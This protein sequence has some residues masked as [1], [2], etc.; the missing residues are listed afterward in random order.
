MIWLYSILL[1][2]HLLGFVSMR[3]LPLT[4]GSVEEISLKANE[5]IKLIYK[6]DIDSKDAFW[7]FEAHSQDNADQLVLSQDEKQMHHPMVQVGNHQGLVFRLQGDDSNATK[8]FAYLTNKRRDRDVDLVVLLQ[9]YS[10]EYPVPGFISQSSANQN[11][12]HLSYYANTIE[13]EFHQASTLESTNEES[14]VLSYGVYQHYLAE[15]NLDQQSFLSHLSTSMLNLQD[16]MDNGHGVDDDFVVFINDTKGK[17][18][19]AAYPGTGVIFSV[20]ATRS[21]SDANGTKH[22]S[23]LY[24]STSTYAC[25]LERTD[26][27]PLNC[28]IM[29]Y[30]ITKVIC[31]A[32][33]FVG[34]LRPPNAFYRLILI[35]CFL[36]AYVAFFGHR[37]F[38]VITILSCFNDS[39]NLP[40]LIFYR[41]RSSYLALMARECALLSS[42]R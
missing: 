22:Y 17:V 35:S 32:S 26:D 7:T 41:L 11:T 29:W 23:S 37:S 5:T 38:T 2:N 13:L 18:T 21:I 31:G 27:D 34:K 33:L 14:A 10:K 4:K 40:I 1:F 15:R 16:I 25:K 3:D 8:P 28:V 42:Y 30:T 39:S 20:I 36:G 12:L 24:V 9:G 6:G 19:F